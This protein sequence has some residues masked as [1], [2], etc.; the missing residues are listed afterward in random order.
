MQQHFERWEL[1]RP[2]TCSHGFPVAYFTRLCQVFEDL[3]LRFASDF[4]A[5]IALPADHNDTAA[6]PGQV[7]AHV[8]DETAADRTAHH[9]SRSGVLSSVRR[10]VDCSRGR[11][12][13]RNSMANPV[14]HVF[15]EKLRCPFGL[16]AVVS[17]ATLYRSPDSCSVLYVD[18]RITR[19]TDPPPDT[20]RPDQSDLVNRTLGDFRLLRRLGVGGMAEVYLA[21]QISLRRSVAV[22]ILREDAVSGKNNTL[23]Q[24]FEQEARAAGGL[25]HPNIVQVYMIGHGDDLHYIVQEY[26]QGQNLSQWIKRNGPPDFLTGLKWIKNVAA[27]LRAASDA[28]VVHRDIKP[29]NIMLTRGEVAKVTDFG[30][31]QLNEV[32]EKMNLTQD[33]TTM[34][35]PWYMSPEQI[36]GEK[37]DHRTDQ[38]SFGVSCYHMFAGQPPFP[39]K[40]SVSV[41]IQH[42]KEEAK[43]LSRHR[44]DLPEAMCQTIH[45]MMEKKPEDR[46]ATP[47]ELQDALARLDHAPLNPAIADTS[48]IWGWLRSSLPS[49]LTAIV[50]ILVCCVLGMALGQRFFRP[51]GLHIKDAEFT[52]EDT[53]T[54]Q[55]ARAMLNTGNPAAW[56]AVFDKFPET[57]EALWARLHLGVHYLTKTPPAPSKS[58]ETF[59][60]LIQQASLTPTEN[61]DV[62][63]LAY[64]GRAL[65]A[66]EQGNDKL[67]D[68]LVQTVLATEYAAEMSESVVPGPD[69]LQEYRDRLKEDLGV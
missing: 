38:Y 52:P 64:L 9:P 16:T 58:G 33:G 63:F 43:P 13:D 17:S 53:A 22:K 44:R 55:Y 68:E 46:F 62:L 51:N 50:A 3:F 23:L 48:T 41:A 7:R 39:G 14:T 32:T 54:Q 21:E 11:F 27:A 35:T 26:V 57:D 5:D 67:R 4:V 36:Q 69:A 8:R 1:Y 42:L 61:R 25:S 24:R 47:Q 59:Q 34:G 12:Y 18:R 30:L 45:R 20:F 6:A 56:E 49:P 40:N 10:P 29:E 15:R 65:A 37:L 60:E 31:A 19:M 2:S 66:D 28:G